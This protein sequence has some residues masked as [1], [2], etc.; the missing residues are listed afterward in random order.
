MEKVNLLKNSFKTRNIDAYLVP[1][2]DEFQN[3][4]S[5]ECLQRLKWL[6]NFSGSNGLALITKD[7]NY[8]FTD[9]RYLIQA[10]NQLSDDYLIFNIQ[11]A[12]DI[13]NK[14]FSIISSNFSVGYDPFIFSKWALE[15]FS[16]L[17]IKDVTNIKLVPLEGNLIDAIWNRDRNFKTKAPLILDAKYTSETETQK[18]SKLIDKLKAD[19]I[20]ITSPES[21][22]WLLNIRGID[23]KY[24][25]LIMA[26]CLISKQGDIEIFSNLKK[27]KSSYPSIKLL[28]FENIKCRFLELDNQNKTIQLDHSQTPIWF[29][30]NFQKN[31]LLIDK[32]PCILPKSIKNNIE[33]AG[34][35]YAT[36]QDGIALTKLFSWLEVQINAGEEVTEI[37][38]DKKL[39]YFKKQNPLFK[40]KSFETISSFGKNSAIIHYNPYDGDNSK[41]GADNLFLLDCGSQ[42]EFGTT[43]VT[44][45][46]CFGVPSTPQKLYYT[47]VLKGLIHLSTLIFPQNTSG[48]QIDAL[49]RQFLWKYSLDYPHGT[50]HGVGHYLSVH[51]GPQ[52]INKCNYQELKNNMI[53]TIE[54]GYYIPKKYGI[55]IENIV[56]VKAIDNDK[57]FLQ[58]ETLTLAPIAYNLINT[59]L[60]ITHEKKWLLSYHQKVNN[61]L[62]PFLDDIEKKYLEKHLQF[63]G[64]LT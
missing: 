17:Y 60:L 9:D 7:K 56:L 42:Y 8:L 2:Y 32:N 27:I 36:I 15:N 22:C 58:F 44:R 49:A 18:I 23:L 33:V 40:G 28:P 54:P 50:G 20:L 6:T 31:N 62:S 48:S 55:R 26:Y 41:V 25:P 63:Y 34:I 29:I 35:K 12:D 1:S 61:S 51:E 11:D 47:L 16:K 13:F 14:I 5:P 4:Y 19:Y 10:K 59:E 24:T 30:D 39:S 43:D 21:I 52:G 38:I 64:N 45:T 3:E 53:V 57:G 37:D 46:L